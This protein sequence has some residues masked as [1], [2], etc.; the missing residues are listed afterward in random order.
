MDLSPIWT[1]TPARLPTEGA[2]WVFHGES[3]AVGGWMGL[4]ITDPEKRAGPQGGV[5][6]REL[7]PGDQLGREKKV[8]TGDQRFTNWVPPTICFASLQ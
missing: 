7:S 3:E 6:A 1:H 2:Q 5:R 4:S 8:D